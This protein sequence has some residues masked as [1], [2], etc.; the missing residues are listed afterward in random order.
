LPFALLL[1]D[2][3][4]GHHCERNPTF[5]IAKVLLILAA[6]SDAVRKVINVDAMLFD[7]THNLRKEKRVE[8]TTRQSAVT[9]VLLE[10]SQLVG[11]HRVRLPDHGNDV[12][13]AVQVSHKLDVDLFQPAPSGSDEVEATVDSVVNDLVSVDLDLRLEILVV[14]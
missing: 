4:A 5:Q 13:F 10:A 12:H 11:S 7:V 1:V 8:E 9:Y 14:L 2:M 6:R 3:I